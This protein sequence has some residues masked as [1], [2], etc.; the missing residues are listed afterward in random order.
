MMIKSEVIKTKTSEIWI[1]DKGILHVKVFEGAEMNYDEVVNNF[2]VYRGLGFGENNKVLQFMD[3]RVNCTM[4]KEGREYVAENAKDFFIASTVIT[5]NLAVRLI[6]N[7]INKFYKL[8]VPFKLFDTEEKG[9]E[10][11]LKFRK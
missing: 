9:M 1:D 11:L 7:F 10:W 2:N 6:A 8:E 5:N 3:A 4:S